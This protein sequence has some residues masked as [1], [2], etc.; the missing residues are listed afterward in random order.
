MAGNLY[1]SYYANIALW[2]VDC[3]RPLWLKNLSFFQ[4]QQVTKKG[5]AET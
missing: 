3:I 2:D 4:L 1:V 5:N